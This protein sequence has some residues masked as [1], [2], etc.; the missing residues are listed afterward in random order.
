[1]VVISDTSVLSN[2][3]QLGR[4]D[5]LERLYQELIIPSSVAIELQAL[6]T[7]VTDLDVFLA[8]EWIHI[9]QPKD[10][11]FVN[12]LKRKLDPGESEAIALA[13]E[14]K[15]DLLLMDELL[16]RAVAEKYGIKISGTLGTL[17]RAKEKGLINPIRPLIDQLRGEIGFWISA[18]LYKNVL[19][20]AGE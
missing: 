15:V 7:N 17:L 9:N 4:I 5:V 18:S 19:Q 12:S 13:V 6:Q 8:E 16:G 20:L 14:L 3:L 2:F 11:N 10:K 1:M